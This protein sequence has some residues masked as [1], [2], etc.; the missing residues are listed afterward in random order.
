PLGPRE[1]E[2]AVKAVGV[3]FK[4]VMV[5][6]GQI[7]DTSLGQECSGVVTAV[8][9]E[10]SPQDF[11]VGD[12]AFRNFARGNKSSV[13][14]IPETMTFATAATIPVTFA[15]A[16]Y[17][18]FHLA[19]LAADESVLIHAAAG[20]VGQ[21]A[22]QLA[23]TRTS[24]SNIFVTVSSDEKRSLLIEQ[25]GILETHIF[26]SRHK[27]FVQG[28]KRMTS[29]RGVDVVLN[30]LA[31]DFL[32]ESL[33]CVAPLGRFIEIGKKD[34]YL[35][36]DISLSR[37]LRSISF[38]SVDLGVI[39]RECEPLMEEIITQA[40]RVYLHGTMQ[41]AQPLTAFK[42][43]QIEEAFRFLQNGRSSGKSVIEFGSDDKIPVVP[44]SK[45]TWGFD[46]NATYV[47]AGGSG[48]LGRSVA[49]WMA[50][51]N[52]KHILLLSRSGTTSEAVQSLITE[53][54]E[55]GTLVAAPSCDVSDEKALKSVLEEYAA[56]LPPIKSRI[57]GSM[58]LRD[59]LFE[60]M[61]HDDFH[62]VLKPKVQGTWNLH[63]LLPR[64]MDFFLILSSTGGVF[65]SR[66]QSNYAAASTYQDA[67]AKYRVGLGEKCV[68]LDLGL[69]LAVG[70][71]AE[72]QHIT[73]KLVSAGY[74]GIHEIEFHALL[75]YFC[76]PGRPID[77]AD[78][79]QTVTGVAVPA[80]L[81]ARGL[82]DIFW[83]SKP[84]FGGLRQMDRQTII[85]DKNPE[86]KIDYRALFEQA[87]TDEAAG[88]IITKA[89]TKKLST[90]LNM[91]VTD[92]EPEKPVY[93][94]GVDSLVAVE[95]RYWFLKEFKAQVAVFEI[96]RSESIA[97]L[98]LFV[99]S[100]AQLRHVKMDAS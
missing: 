3:N 23:K 46:P 82:G 63:H 6:L 62:A 15:T 49:R 99:A 52:A 26:S 40:M 22:I 89:L 31:G 44:S 60:A 70:F 72:R 64:Y 18:L 85:S 12:H 95:V 78:T 42:G 88:T 20:G 74:E 21:A 59:G 45:P 79:V 69:M 94:Y 96:L 100:K 76:D 1:I 47:I 36:S 68:S 83:M 37:F 80:S 30:S 43:S 5:A 56:T 91:P 17:S 10:I 16:Y 73:E 55:L 4:N 28:I 90:A 48:G 66:G 29:G 35:R 34:I 53:L 71:A 7:P 11:S 65:G 41:P 87:P 93:A 75:D 32:K 24:A 9:T 84:L 98:S 81:N 13:Y 14:K 54:T 51:R 2:I 92:I 67:F 86:N 50:A 58:V 39:V 38:L 25:Y 27:S 57:Q 97:K 19:R 61:S 8:G 77:D 33:G